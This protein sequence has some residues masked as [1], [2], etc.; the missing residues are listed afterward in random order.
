MGAILYRAPLIVW[1]EDDEALDPILAGGKA[2]GLAKLVRAG[3][4]VPPGFVLTSEAYR[5]FVEET[6]IA[7]YIKYVLDEVIQTGAPEEYEKAAELIRSKFMRSPMPHALH[8]AIVEAYRKLAERIGVENPRVAVRSSATVEDLPEASFAGQQDTYLN[9]V[10]EEELVEHVKKVWASLWTARALSY[11]DSLNIEHES[12]LM[13]VIVQ[14]MVNSRSAGVMFTVHPVTGE[15]DKIVIE[16]AWGLGEY[17]VAGKVTP[18]QFVVDKAELKILERRIRRKERAL[19]YDHVSRSNVEVRLPANEDGIEEIAKR[20][21]EVAGLIKKFSIYSE[22]PSLSEEEVVELAKIGLKIEEHFGKPMDVEWAID[23]D[24]EPPKNIFI[25]QARPVTTLHEE[26]AKPT[27]AVEEVGKILVRGIP[28]S[29]GVATGRV[30]VA[31]TVEEAARKIKRGDVLVTRMTDPDWVPYMKLASAI[32]T[33]AF[34][35]AP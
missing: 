17:V 3:I 13:A 29:P 21:P 35:L 20:N 7:S 8:D 10:G 27:E 15:R 24:I 30:K 26:E 5:F 12:A 11:R 9:V 33:D 1:L 22:A 18:D 23:M 14:K 34:I 6:G 28:A 2:V 25:V 19:F 16:S 32:V 31:L 4:P